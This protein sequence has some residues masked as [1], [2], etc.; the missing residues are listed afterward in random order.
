MSKEFG[1]KIFSISI[2]KEMILIS[3]VRDQIRYEI[4]NLK[5]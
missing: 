5:I 1:S 3:K 4:K 2:E